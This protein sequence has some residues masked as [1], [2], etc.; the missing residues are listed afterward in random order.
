MQLFI[1][2]CQLYKECEY[3]NI[4]VYLINTLYSKQPIVALVDCHKLYMCE[5]IYLLCATDSLHNVLLKNE[6][7]TTTTTTTITTT[8]KVVISS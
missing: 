3:Y 6:A 1:G 8:S 5:L 2:F 7:T 4:C